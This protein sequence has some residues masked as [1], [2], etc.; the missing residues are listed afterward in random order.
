MSKTGASWLPQRQGT[1]AIALVLPEEKFSYG[2][3]N[4]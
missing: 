1:R 2:F 3:P 4:R